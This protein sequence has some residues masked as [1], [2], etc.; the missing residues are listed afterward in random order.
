MGLSAFICAP[1]PEKEPFELAD[2]RGNGRGVRLAELV[3]LVGSV[4]RPN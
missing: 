1:V 2:A 4:A 3:V